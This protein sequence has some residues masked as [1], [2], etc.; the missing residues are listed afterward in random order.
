MRHRLPCEIVI[1]KQQNVGRFA[2][3]IAVRHFIRRHIQ[4][5]S[6]KHYGYF[7][8]KHKGYVTWSIYMYRLY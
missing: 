8:V 5:S 2:S 7:K 3:A 4:M 6:G 1:A